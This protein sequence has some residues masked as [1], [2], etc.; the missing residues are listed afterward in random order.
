MQLLQKIFWEIEK[1][2]EKNY[3]IYFLCLI[4]SI[5]V[6]KLFKTPQKQKTPTTHA[7]RVSV[8]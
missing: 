8:K 6:V 2:A 1:E 3:L 7:A 5:I 4:V